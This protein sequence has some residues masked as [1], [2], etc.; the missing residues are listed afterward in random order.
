MSFISQ[1]LMMLS[2]LIRIYS[3]LL[4]VRV[5]L[6]WIPSL[7]YSSVGNIL[8]QLCDPFLNFFRRIRF[9]QM[10]MLD[11]SP[12]VAI[13]AL[14]LL[15]QLVNSIIVTGQ[16]SLISILGILFLSVFGLV[17]QFGMFLVVLLIVRLIMDIFSWGNRQFLGGIDNFLTGIYGKITYRF[18]KLRFLN[19]RYKLIIMI[20]LCLLIMAGLNSL[21][22][23]VIRFMV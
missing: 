12:I 1:I 5:F 9:L 4:V 14:T 21:R 3:L 18:E 16:F 17:S 8:S 19:F 15:E 11:F 10:G 2:S 22:T 23:L 20:G 6:T 7:N 13:F